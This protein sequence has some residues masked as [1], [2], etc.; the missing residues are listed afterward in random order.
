MK[1]RKVILENFR[2]YKE[3]TEIYLD[4]LTVFIGKNDAGKSSILEALDIFFDGGTVK[5]EASDASKSGDDKN[6]IIGVVFSEPPKQLTLDSSAQSTLEAEYLLNSESQLEIY[7]VY[8]CNVQRV[9][10]PKTFARA[11]HP[12]ADGA[13]ELIQKTNRELKQIVRDRGLETKCKQNENPSMR[14][15]IYLDAGDPV[16]QEQ[17]VPL[18]DENGKAIWTALEKYLPVYALFRSDRPSTDQ[19]SEVQNPMKIAIQKAIKGMDA[20]LEEVT[21]KIREQ[22][23]ETADRTLQQL[24]ASYPELANTLQAQFQPPKWAGIFKLDLESDEGI[25]LNKRGSGVRRLILLSFFQAEAARKQDE[26]RNTGEED[27]RVIYAIEEPETSQHP[28]SQERIVEALR[29]VAGAGDQV[30]LT[31]HVPG[32]ASLIPIESLRFV[33]S[34]P[35]NGEARI[36]SGTPEVLSDIAET[37]GVLPDAVDKP[38][39]R[40]AVLVEGPTDVDVVRSFAEV[41]ANAGEIEAIDFSKVFLAHAGGETL[42]FWVERRYLDSLRLPQVFLFDSDRTSANLPASRSKQ[43]QEAELNARASCRAFMTRKREIENYVHAEAINRLTNGEV[44]IDANVD[45][46][47]DDMEKVFG[48]RLGTAL[49]R[50]GWQFEP[51]DRFGNR[52]NAPSSNAKKVLTGHIMRQMTALEIKERCRYVDDTSGQTAYEVVE[53]LEAILEHVR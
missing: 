37:L 17:D 11:M 52:I 30:L 14:Q 22:A 50:G 7:K 10:A 25:P 51:T 42:K 32:L 33:D 29:E 46:D 44:T 12:T 47:F 20:E 23:Q 35:A 3:R 34:D 39:A 15:A 41:L 9:G 4:D 49:G 48:S 19:D 31:T 24:Q 21:K 40:V 43:R 26:R 27:V 1:I 36:R 38:G 18:N 8:N 6:I 16:L 2:L 13:K 45:L 28:D 5:I 53:W